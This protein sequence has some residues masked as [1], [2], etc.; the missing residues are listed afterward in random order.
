M[1]ASVA[2]QLKVVLRGISPMIWRRLVLAGDSTIVDLHFVLQIA[3]GWRDGHLHRFRIHGREYGIGRRG[4]RSFPDDPHHV[5]LTDLAFQPREH[6]L[7]EYDFHD[8]WQHDIRV[9]Q[10]HPVD[11]SH[12]YPRC[13][14]GKRAGPPEDCGGAWAFLEHRQRY[15]VAYVA[16]RLAVIYDEDGEP[17][18]RTSCRAELAAALPWLRLEQFDR[19]TVNRRLRQYA[20]GD[21]AWRDDLPL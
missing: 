13:V 6:F 19:R 7:Y 18:M 10:I 16:Q 14:A 3:F 4:G 15:S 17:D 20:A 5:H 9:E 21:D 12:A 1:S 2:Y 8:H 11:P